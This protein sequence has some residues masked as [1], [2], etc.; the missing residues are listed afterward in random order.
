[1]NSDSVLD[2]DTLHF[3]PITDTADPT[4]TNIETLARLREFAASSVSFAYSSFKPSF[5]TFVIEGDMPPG[6][7][8]SRYQSGFNENAAFRNYNGISLALVMTQRDQ[9]TATHSP[10]NTDLRMNWAIACFLGR[11][12]SLNR[13]FLLILDK[14]T[15][16]W[17]TYP[18]KT[19]GT[20][21]PVEGLKRY[22]TTTGRTPRYLCIDNAKEF[23]SQERVDFCSEHNIIWQSVVAT[24]NHTMQCRVES[25]IDCSKQHSRVELVYANVP[26]RCWPYDTIAFTCKKNVLWAKHDEHGERATAN[27]RMQSAFEGS[28]KTV[29]ILFGSCVMKYLPVEHLLV[30]NG[31][32]GDRLWH[33]RVDHDTPCICMYCITSGSQL[34]VHNFKSYPNGFPFRDPSCLLRCTPV[35]LKDLAKMHIDDA[36]DDNL[37][38]VAEETALHANK[39]AQTRAAD[40]AKVLVPSY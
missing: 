16:Y 38:L 7:E 32:F 20:G 23:T 14:S 15:K 26:T 17:A 40:A 5:P 27:D 8:N 13:Y 6:S 9:P 28:F 19:R 30:K 1:M 4:S 3:S 2:S 12:P 10:P 18:R 21:T 31:S 25:V 22:I 37:R 34:P 36:R 29:D 24:D 35:F 11:L 39:R 33:R